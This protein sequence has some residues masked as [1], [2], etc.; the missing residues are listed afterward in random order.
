MPTEQ[1][2]GAGQVPRGAEGVPDAVPHREGERDRGLAPA[3]L[4]GAGQR[5]RAGAGA[6]AAL[7]QRRDAPGPAARGAG[8]DAQH[9]QLRHSPGGQCRS[10]C[11]LAEKGAPARALVALTNT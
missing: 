5:R 7:L 11:S 8:L 2:G 6:A 3:L 10:G 4:P 9:R 1:R